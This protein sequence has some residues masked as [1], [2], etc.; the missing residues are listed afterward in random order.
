LQNFDLVN[1]ERKQHQ[2]STL[3]YSK[4]NSETAR[5]HSKDMA[6]N[7]YFDHTNLKGQSP[8]DRLKKDG[9]TFNSAGENLAYGQVSSIYAH[10]GLMNSIGHR[11]NILNDTFKI[12]GVGVDFNDEKQPFWTE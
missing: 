6:K 11:K 7:H 2:L 12:L 8:F 10:Q 5:K 3:K 1:A 9:I 4:Q